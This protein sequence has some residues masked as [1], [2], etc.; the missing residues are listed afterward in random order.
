[1]GASLIG[2]DSKITRASIH[3]EELKAQF[4]DIEE[5]DAE[6]IAYHFDEETGDHI[7]RMAVEPPD[8]PVDLS[9]VV[10]DTLYN[11]RSCLDHL[12]WQLV[13]LNSKTPN[14]G[15][16][17]PIFINKVEYEKWKQTKLK[18]ISAE[19]T[20][21]IHSIQ[22]CNG[23]GPTLWFLEELCNI[24]KHRHFNLMVGATNRGTLSGPNVS[25]IKFTPHVGPVKRDTELLRIHG[26]EVN[27]KFVPVFE[28]L[29]GDVPAALWGV[30]SLL[31]QL[32]IIV[33][34]IRERLAPQFG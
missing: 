17:F 24:D 34:Q 21:I 16:A 9:A 14:R 23:G 20:A 25:T 31:H 5:L 26:R 15:N 7:W 19:A 3:L 11:L 18:G 6:S 33:H 30:H 4:A 28:I 8:I 1:M 13:L 22:P 32:L 29:F 12:V 2:V 10:G 27:V